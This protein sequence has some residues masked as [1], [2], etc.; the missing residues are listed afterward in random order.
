MVRV[1]YRGPPP[2]E[3]TDEFFFTDYRGRR[4]MVENPGT[5]GKFYLDICF[6]CRAQTRPHEFGK[7]NRGC[8]LQDLLYINK[9]ELV[10]DVKTDRN[11][12]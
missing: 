6:T 10:K 1:P 5:H 12:H 3:E 9:E 2:E 11:L 8:T 4:L 7:A